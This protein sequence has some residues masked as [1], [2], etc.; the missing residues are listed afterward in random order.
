M[1]RELQRW[2]PE[3]APPAGGERRLRE[4]LAARRREDAPAWQ[5]ALAAVCC[6]LLLALVLPAPATRRQAPDIAHALDLPP[7]AAVW[8]ADGAA[9]EV[10]VGAEGVRVVLVM[11]RDE[12]PPLP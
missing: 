8:V 11:D 4:A 10:P 9:L 12:T 3:R 5:P 2:L 1:A 7:P 6:V